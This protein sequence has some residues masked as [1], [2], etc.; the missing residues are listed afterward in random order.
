MENDIPPY[1][2]NEME[3]LGVLPPPLPDEVPDEPKFKHQF[4]YNMPVLDENGEPPF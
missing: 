1:I 2:L 3:H 4:E